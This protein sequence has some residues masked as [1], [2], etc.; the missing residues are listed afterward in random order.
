MKK[1]LIRLLAVGIVLCICV[2][3]VVAL[4]SDGYTYT[5]DYWGDEQYSPDAY[6]V[7]GVFT[8]DELGLDKKLKNPQGLFV[9]DDMIYICDTGNNRIIQI[10]REGNEFK[11]VREITQFNGNGKAD[12]NTLASPNDIY[13]ME[14]G[15]MIICDTDNNRV[16]KLDKDLN[17]LL[18]FTKPTDATF[19]QS[20]AYL[21]VKAVA[22]ETGRVFVLGK[23]INKGIIKYENNGDF[24]GFVGANKV[25]ITWYERFWKLL[26]TQAQRAQQESFVP[27]EYDNLNIDKDGFIYAVTGTFAVDEL[28]TDQAYPIRK[29]NTV[30]NDI[31]IKNGNYPPI[32]DL[33][34][35]SRGS[36]TGPSRMKD[37][38]AFDNGLYF[39]LDHI[40]N[41]VFGYDNQGNMLFAF[42][43]V[44]NM[45]GY[46]QSPSAIEHMG[47]DLLVLDS[48][49]CSLTVFTPTDYC[50]L[51]YKAIDEYTTG[52]Y[53]TSSKT[54]A[55]VLEYNGNF[56][57]AYIGVGRSLLRQGDYK[58][59][60][61]YF[62]LTWDTNNYSKAFKLYRKQWVE[63]H[64]GFIFLGIVIILVVPLAV[65]KVKKIKQEVE[66]A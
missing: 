10:Q 49:D 20:L 37:I 7:L 65:G 18:A 2:S 16:V 28:K 23:N 12:N 38:T 15:D 61:E 48:Q 26:S 9:R 3:P 33:Q 40:R 29:L 14:N 19:D 34:W 43:G 27:T 46:F 66:N 56:D 44:G 53:D 1:L 31:L 35:T 45:N 57:L 24:T 17:F 54:W 39:A 36:I 58:K 42:G 11:L 60:M 62:K 8:N 32:G 21:P 63:E 22:D 6:R 25:K 30:G 13:V 50:N 41:R 52:E 5:Y 4:A 64:I 47:T 51:I 59:A 55:K